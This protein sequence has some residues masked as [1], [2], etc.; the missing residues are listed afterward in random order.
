MTTLGKILIF[1]NLVFSVIVGILIGMV[2]AARTNWKAAY[3]KL[4]AVNK[5]NEALVRTTADDVKAAKKA[6]EDARK[7]VEAQVAQLVKQVDGLQKQIATE[8]ATAQI[9]IN[10]ANQLAATNSQNN[11]ELLQR[12]DEV[13]QLQQIVAQRD[14]Q[15][16]E[17]Q[18]QKKELR[19]RFVRAD[20]AARDS[21]RRAQEALGTIE[22]LTQEMDRLKG[23]PSLAGPGGRKPPDDVK[24]IV[25]Q[26]AKDGLISVSLGSDAGLS[27]GNVL[28]VYRLAPEAKYLGE[29]KILEVD[30]HEAVG[31]MTTP[32]RTAQLQRGDTVA[33]RI[34][35]AH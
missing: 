35:E 29:I 32:Q 33:S 7:V 31:R 8:R 3:T 13:R 21:H 10:E 12:R 25:T 19:D 24:G 4:E 20:I 11:A 30:H 14:Q 5:V 17:E 27:K 2:F 9:K 22:R 23:G 26:V 6:G 15:L 1:V 18:T 28:Q 34:M 16:I